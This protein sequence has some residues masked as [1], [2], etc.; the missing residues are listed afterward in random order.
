MSEIEFK[1]LIVSY[2]IDSE[3]PDLNFKI[4]LHYYSIGQTASAVSFFIRTAERAPDDLLKYQS[5]LLAARCFES[6]GSRGFSVKG[7]LQHALALLP[8]RPEA[9][10]LLA[11]YYES[12]KK[13]GSWFDCYLI[14]SVGLNVIDFSVGPLPI[15]VGYPGKYAI[16]FEKALSSWWCGLCEESKNLFVDL[17]KN[18]NMSDTFRVAVI[19]NLKHFGAFN[20]KSIK[21][22][23]KE[24][25]NELCYQFVDSDHI[26]KN[27]S[28]SYQDMFVLTMLNGKKHGTYLEVGA[29]N[30][31]YGSNTALLEQKFLWK[32]LAIDFDENFVAAHN[33]ERK[34][35]CILRDATLIDY[36]KF[37]SGL[38]FPTVIDY[39]QIDCDPSETSY[40]VLTTIPFEKYK[41]AVITYEHDEYSDVN[42]TYKEKSRKY[43][44]NYGYVMVVGDIAPD[45]WRNYEDWWVHPDLVDS[46][47]LAKMLD[48]SNKTKNAEDYMLG[49]LNGEKT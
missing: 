23:T 43:L 10:F 39:L 42:K 46:D 24:K 49:K 47:I 16:L 6:Q 1:N 27:Y 48:V 9:Y 19:N 34:N 32:G 2:I 7:L 11:K 5:L 26:E 21:Y 25:H 30:P 31:F 15:D 17:L 44:S 35:Q 29:G 12:E 3:N 18:Y 36:D 20:T 33:K 8:S 14:T 13:D 37:L 45:D 41:F 22:Y 40:K 4:A 38:E 28:E